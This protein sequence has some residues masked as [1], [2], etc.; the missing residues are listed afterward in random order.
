MSFR[1]LNNNQTCSAL[2]S[3]GTR[4]TTLACACSNIPYRWQVGQ[5]KPLSLLLDRRCSIQMQVIIRTNI[6][7]FHWTNL[8]ICLQE[9]LHTNIRTVITQ[10]DIKKLSK[11][12]LILLWL[13][14]SLKKRAISS[15]SKKK[16]YVITVLSMIWSVLFCSSHKQEWIWN[17]WRWMKPL[18]RSRYVQMVDQ[19]YCCIFSGSYV[20]GSLATLLLMWRILIIWNRKKD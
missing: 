14:L 12:H 1:L 15:V 7:L 4:R 18:K 13:L 3:E 2:W 20:V 19:S 5:L 6:S 8:T 17:W 9:K 10:P 11:S 16:V